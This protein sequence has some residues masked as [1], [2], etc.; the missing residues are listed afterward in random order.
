MA[1]QLLLNMLLSITWMFLNNDWT[2]AGFIIGFALGLLILI[3]FRRFFHQPLYVKKMWAIVKLLLIFTKEL[4]VSSFAVAKHVVSPKLNMRPGIFT[5]RTVLQSD[6]EVTILACLICLT[7]GTLTL[8]ISRDSR[9]L[10]IHAMDIED[11]DELAEQ[12]KLS[13][14]RAILEVRHA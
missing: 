9:T 14:E 13:F 7:P 5:F 4:F 12:I 3:A 6:W 11:A 8:E 10:F 1:F 2:A